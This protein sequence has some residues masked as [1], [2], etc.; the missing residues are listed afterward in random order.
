[1]VKVPVPA[2][3][4]KP[5]PAPKPTPASQP[6]VAAAGNPTEAQ[7]DAGAAGYDEPD[8]PRLSGG[9]FANAVVGLYFADYGDAG[10][11]EVPAALEVGAD[12]GYLWRLN[13]TLGVHADVS[14][15]YDTVVH[16]GKT[17][18]VPFGFL[19]VFFGGGLRLYFWRVW[20]DLRVAVG[21]ALLVGAMDKQVFLFPTGTVPDGVLTGFALRTSLSLGWTF[22]KGLTLTVYPAAIE[23]T[24]AME[25]FKDGVSVLRYQLALALGWQG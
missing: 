23:Y 6:K 20:A 10:L 15:L 16:S 2:P 19:N 14:L 8:P 9:P 24:P 12:V 7:I 22:W 25:G 13:S 3:K 18:D 1:M 17:E 21:P 5:A 4:P 11:S